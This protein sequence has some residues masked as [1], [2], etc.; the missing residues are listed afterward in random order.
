MPNSELEP[1]LT[2]GVEPRDDV[3]TAFFR[4]FLP[5]FYFVN[6]PITRM[7]RHLHLMFELAQ[8]PFIIDFHRPIGAQFTELTLCAG[9][10][11]QPGLLSE[12]AG[13]LSWLRIN[14]QTAWIHTLL[15]P[16]AVDSGRRIVL[17]TF[18]LA[19]RHSGQLRPLSTLAQKR[20]REALT[21]VLEDQ[22][23]AVQRLAK[24]LRRAHPMV[25]EEL[26]VAPGAEGSL[27]ITLRAADSEAVLFR[28][29]RVLASMGLDIAH[30]QIDTQEH[31]FTDTFFVFKSG[32]V[33]ID[34]AEVPSLQTQ[35][36]A[37]LSAE[38]FSG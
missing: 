4:A 17:D 24:T 20:V 7:R 6:T 21:P 14:V 5:D 37:A 25:I 16:H 26:L 29:T 18:I 35:L 2:P 23:S 8:T 31:S 32:N 28:I 36:H 12:V 30:A 34:R 13:T 11:R 9:D 19:E 38:N 3:V 10:G 33:R 15:D 27:Q 22:S 1:G